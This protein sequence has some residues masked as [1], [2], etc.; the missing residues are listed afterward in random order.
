MKWYVNWTCSETRPSV[1]SN[2]FYGCENGL[3]N[4]SCPAGRVI[5]SGTVKYGRWDNYI[6]SGP[7]VNISTPSV[8]KTLSLPA[9]CL[10]TT[11][12]RI[13]SLAQ[14]FGDPLPGISK[15]VNEIKIIFY[16]SCN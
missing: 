1:Q 14:L 6:C 5:T 9:N 4:P 8:Y 12:C 3:V 2:G 7:G 10:N 13:P 11:S 16:T 15:H